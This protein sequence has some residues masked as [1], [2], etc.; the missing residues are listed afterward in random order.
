AADGGGAILVD[1]RGYAQAHPRAEVL[2]EEILAARTGLADDA[3]AEK[4]GDERLIQDELVVAVAQPHA[5]RHQDVRRVVEFDPGI[6]D[7]D[8]LA[9]PVAGRP[10]FQ[11]QRGRGTGDVDRIPVVSRPVYDSALA[12]ADERVRPVIQREQDSI[13]SLCTRRLDA[14]RGAGA[15]IVA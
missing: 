13:E 4:A 14:D 11:S 2:A 10:G 5:R 3:D 9:G 1:R 8:E 7:V 15:V 6:E 12:G